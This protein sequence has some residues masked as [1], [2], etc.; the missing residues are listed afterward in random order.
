MK[1]SL[2][3]R[4]WSKVL[5]SE[6]GCWEWIAGRNTPNG[7]GCFYLGH[8][9]LLAHR[10][11]YELHYGDP[12]ELLVCH[13]CDNKGCVRPDHFFLGTA[14]ENILDAHRK[15]LVRLNPP[16]G[17]RCPWAKLTN[18]IV[19]S[20]RARYA[21]GGISFKTLGAQFGVSEMTASRAVRGESWKHI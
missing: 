2:E 14:S 11:S 13:K 7:Y 19:H 20:L 4:F 21:Q 5:K 6:H 9:K 10:Y 16:K 3:A 15:G 17:E 18:E 1:Q 12:G 8:K